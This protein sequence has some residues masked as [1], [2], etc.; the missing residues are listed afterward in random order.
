MWKNVWMWSRMNVNET[1][2]QHFNEV[3][4]RTHR[5]SLCISFVQRGFICHILICFKFGFMVGGQC[6]VH[7]LTVSETTH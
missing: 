3:Q 4:W 6:A 2:Q 1:E 5:V 7:L